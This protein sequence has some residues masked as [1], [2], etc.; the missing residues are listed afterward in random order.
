[1]AP[2]DKM[3]SISLNLNP[4]TGAPSSVRRSVRLATGFVNPLYGFMT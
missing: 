1:V 3:S 2:A 4:I